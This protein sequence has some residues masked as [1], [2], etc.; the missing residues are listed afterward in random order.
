MSGVV[1]GR[2][3]ECGG[4]IVS[5]ES[6]AGACSHCSQTVARRPSLPR[7]RRRGPCSPGK[8]AKGADTGG[9]CRRVRNEP[10]QDRPGPRRRPPRRT[11]P[12][13]KGAAGLRRDR[14]PPEYPPWP[15]VRRW[16]RRVSSP[17]KPALCGGFAGVRGRRGEIGCGAC[18]AGRMARARGV[19]GNFSGRCGGFPELGAMPPV[20][21][22]GVGCHSRVAARAQARGRACVRGL[23]NA[24]TEKSGERSWLFG[25]HARGDTGREG[26]TAF[27]GLRKERPRCANE[28]TAKAKGK[29]PTKEADHPVLP[30]LPEETGDGRLTV[31]RRLE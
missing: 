25:G 26:D 24:A 1:A 5:A 7:P 6:R 16:D 28:G 19:R 27:G 23:M 17:R 18:E 29:L 12:S 2:G 10:P 31:R 11:Q 3:A 20:V 14:L 8:P 4:R 15:V 22:R 9:I 30:E 21:G 13:P